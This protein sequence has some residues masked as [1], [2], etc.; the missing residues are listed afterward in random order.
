[1]VFSFQ[2]FIICFLHSPI[3]LCK[4]LV[5]LCLIVKKLNAAEFFENG[6]RDPAN[7]VVINLV[8]L[9]LFESDLPWQIRIFIDN[10][11]YSLQG[12]FQ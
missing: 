7:L 5:F 3:K 2:K 6:Y 12:F 1:M 10:T 11:H 4:K 9:L 8:P